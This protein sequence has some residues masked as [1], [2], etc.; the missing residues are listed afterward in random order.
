MLG[1]HQQALRADA[2]ELVRTNPD[3]EVVGVVM[4]ADASEARDFVAVFQRATG[5]QP[6]GF[7]GLMPRAQVVDIL[8]QN[9]PATLDMLPP[10]R[11]E[12]GARLLP[13]C[14]I[15]RHGYRFGGIP[16]GE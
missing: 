1:E 13:L 10:S 2:L 9:A 4:T 5:Q 14:V 6:P 15:T 3:F 16:Y 12:A 11:T 7:C 8:R